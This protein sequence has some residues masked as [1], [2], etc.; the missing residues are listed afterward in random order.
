MSTVDDEYCET[1]ELE[2][3]PLYVYVN[4]TLVFYS[5]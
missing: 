3:T 2:A 5:I 4:V 1:A